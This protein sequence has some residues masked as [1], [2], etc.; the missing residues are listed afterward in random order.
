MT[1]SRTGRQPVLALRGAVAAPH[2]GAAQAGLMM[3]QRGGSAVDA[4][5]AANAVLAVVYPHMAG[6]GAL[7]LGARLAQPAL[8]RTLRAIASDG[9]DGFYRG[10]IAERLC[11]YLQAGGGLLTPD[12][13]AANRADWVPPISA[14]YRDRTVFQ[15]PPNT[16]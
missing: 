12:D 5:I 13:F 4:A 16:Q 11:A 8:A 1:L 7:Q 9:P 6:G 2:H 15:L 3:L 14:P 10:S